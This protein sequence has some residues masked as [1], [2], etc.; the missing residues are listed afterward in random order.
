MVRRLTSFVRALKGACLLAATLACSS[1]P[2]PVEPGPAATAA[3]APAAA[4]APP[5]AAASAEPPPASAPEVAIPV[6]AA[7]GVGPVHSI[8]F[9]EKKRAAMGASGIWLDAGSGWAAM[10]PIGVD[11]TRSRIFFGRDDQPRV[12]GAAGDTF[13][14]MRFRLGVWKKGDEEIAGLAANPRAPLY[15]V[16]GHA[17]P[18]VVCKRGGDC[19]IKRRSGWT[20]FKAPQ[21][22]GLPLVE[23]CGEQPWAF[24]GAVIWKVVNSGFTPF[25]SAPTF[26]KA[27]GLWAVGDSDIWVVEAGA[28]KVHH[29]DGKAWQAGPSP[30]RG[31]RSVWASGARDVWIAGAGGAAHYD[32]ERWSRVAGVRENMVT[33][34]GRSKDEVWVGGEA[35]LFRL[36]RAPQ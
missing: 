23:L 32:G 3:P 10:P 35:G 28:S 33:V 4:S 36:G 12:V 34:N 16:L 30:I 1:S 5:A 18:E 25:G 17:D 14:Y 27:D 2:D 8:A 29:W 15:A 20:I 24:D 21:T 9:G 6:E 19:I 11:T 7:A 13:V 31:P 22:T 26:T